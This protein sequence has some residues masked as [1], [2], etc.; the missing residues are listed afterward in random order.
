VLGRDPVA[1]Y[2]SQESVH[3]AFDGVDEHVAFQVE[4]P[5]ATTAVCTASHNSYES[6]HLR[7]TETDGEILIEPVFMPWEDREVTVWRGDV[8]ASFDFE[9]VNQMTEEF[10]YFANC[11]QR[12]VDPHPDGEHGLVDLKTLDALYESAEHNTRIAVEG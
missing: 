2:A 12:G 11:L 10:D 3:E 6:D 7:F 9:Q 8:E 5:G 1:V 4:F